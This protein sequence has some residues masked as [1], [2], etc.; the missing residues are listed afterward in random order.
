M[1]VHANA[2]QRRD[3][4]RFGPMVVRAVADNHD[5]NAGAF[6]RRAGPGVVSRFGE[7]LTCFESGSARAAAALDAY[8]TAFAD[9]TTHLPELISPIARTHSR[10]TP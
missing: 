1:Q 7:H 2:K 10:A 6:L 8:A 5:H 3:F 9:I 4:R